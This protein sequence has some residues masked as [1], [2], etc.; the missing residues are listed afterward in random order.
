M[1]SYLFAFSSGCLVTYLM[2]MI[3]TVLLSHLALNAFI[4]GSVHSW[5]CR[6]DNGCPGRSFLASVWFRHPWLSQWNSRA[7]NEELAKLG[8]RH[9]A[10]YFMPLNISPFHLQNKRARV[11]RQRASFTPKTVKGYVLVA[12]QF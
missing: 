1:A 2:F 9:W 6:A 10:R 8:L 4:K 11:P 12:G 7:L 3:I 5:L